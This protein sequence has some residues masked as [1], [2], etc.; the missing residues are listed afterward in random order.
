MLQTVWWKYENVS[1]LAFAPLH[2]VYASGNVIKFLLVGRKLNISQPS[3][4][5]ASVFLP[6]LLPFDE[7]FH[8]H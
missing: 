2:V 8:A 6:P 4:V 3:D 7:L 5:L 1:P